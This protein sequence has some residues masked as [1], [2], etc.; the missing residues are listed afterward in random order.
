MLI[1]QESA[2]L[3]FRVKPP[4]FGQS[5]RLISYSRLGSTE[6]RTREISERV[7]LP[8]LDALTNFCVAYRD[9]D[10]SVFP[11]AP[12]IHACVSWGS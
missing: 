10:C 1:S 6:V 7:T 11:Q 2:K 12:T 9:T 4:P 5:G 8:N 3:V